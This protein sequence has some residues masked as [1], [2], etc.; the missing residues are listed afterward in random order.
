MVFPSLPLAAVLLVV[1]PTPS[2]LGGGLF[3]LRLPMPE[4]AG[5]VAPD[6]QVDFLARQC[7][8]EVLGWDL[9]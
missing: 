8:L 9:R 3:G 5:R 4:F 1:L 7:R 6:D 2:G